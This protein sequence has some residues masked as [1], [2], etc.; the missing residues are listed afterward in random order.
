[1]LKAIILVVALMLALGSSQCPGNLSPG[2]HLRT[3]RYDGRER[4]FDLHIPRGYTNKRYALILAFH[5]YTLGADHMASSSDLAGFSDETNNFIVAFPQGVGDSWNAGSCCGSA[6]LLQLDDYGLARALVD[7]I[8]RLACIDPA[9]VFTTG[10]S[11]GCFLSQ[12]LICKAPDV[13]A[14]SACGSGGNVMLTVCARDFERF[15]ETLNVLEIHGTADGIVP[16]Y[17]NPLLGFPPVQKNFEDNSA[18]LNCKNGPRVTHSDGN[19]RCEEMYNCDGGTVVEQCTVTL[20]LHRWYDD[21][22]S[23]YILDF[24]G[25]RPFKRIVPALDENGEEI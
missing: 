10:F 22:N 15:N 19:I 18:L 4:E 16:Y 8:S 25:L 2:N 21:F 11:N 3:I 12:G 14:A 9:Q 7:E 5:G 13:F 24:F 20:G 6:V 17:G 23:E 1:M